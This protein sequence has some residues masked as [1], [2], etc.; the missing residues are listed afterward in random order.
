MGSSLV[1]ALTSVRSA[2]AVTSLTA[3]GLSTVASSLGGSSVAAGLSSVAALLS[4]VALVL[5]SVCNRM[6][7][8]SQ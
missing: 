2:S 4:S 5:A 1:L 7:E 3:L 8:E 6:R